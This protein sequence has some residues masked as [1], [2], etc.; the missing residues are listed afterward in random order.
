MNMSQL[1]SWSNNNDFYR[2]LSAINRNCFGALERT[3]FSFVVGSGESTYRRICTIYTAMY[4]T[5]V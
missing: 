1:M 5:W 3:S 2:V 4:E